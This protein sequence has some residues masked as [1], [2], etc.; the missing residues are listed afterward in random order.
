[1]PDRPRAQNPW[2]LIRPKVAIP[3]FVEF[4][5]HFRALATDLTTARDMD[6]LK[7]GDDADRGLQPG[8]HVILA[9]AVSEIAQPGEEFRVEEWLL[10]ENE[11]PDDD[12]V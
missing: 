7:T 3:V 1:M 8:D 11:R 6:Y 10:R 9:G 12:D 2:A 4:W 5:E